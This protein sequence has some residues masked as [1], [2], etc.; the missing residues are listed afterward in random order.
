MTIA[1]S[2]WQRYGRLAETGVPEEVSRWAEQC[3][4]DWWGVTLAGSNEPVAQ[5]LREEYVDSD[6]PA[7]VLGTRR[8]VD[9]ATAALINGAASHALDFDDANFSS[10]PSAYVMP[11]ALALAE[12]EGSSGSELVAAVIA[13]YELSYRVD[14]AMGQV[15]FANGWHPTKALGVFGALAAA[16]ALL[17]LDDTE[18]GHAFGIAASL[19]SGLQANFGTMTKPLHAGL[20]AQQ[21]ILAAHL[22]R[23]GITANPESL[24]AAGGLAELMAGGPV[25]RDS[26]AAKADEWVITRTIFKFHASCLGTH[27]SIGAASSAAAGLAPA[28]IACVRVRANS[29]TRRICRFDYPR[30]GLEAKFS[31]RASVALALLG[32]DTSDPSTFSDERVR[33]EP[34]LQMMKR[35]DV[36]FEPDVPRQNSFVMIETVDGH[37]HEG[38]SDSSIPSDDLDAQETRLRSKFLRNAAPALGDAD[39]AANVLLTARQHA[40]AAAFT[41]IAGA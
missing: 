7:S 25:R 39:A 34:F 2:L 3:L 5:L 12:A 10:H 40:T 19:S 26:L 21:G 9:V 23:R 27:A 20:A 8:H 32:D 41:A 16:G 1:E 35:I 22:A 18:F 15:I 4:L 11:A 24:E 31:V 14:V 30:T 6:G 17:H 33:S 13:G 36:R 28:T 37:R 29:L 38:H